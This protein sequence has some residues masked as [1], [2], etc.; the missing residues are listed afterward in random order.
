MEWLEIDRRRLGTGMLVFGVSGVLIATVVAIALVLGG[1]AVRDLDDRLEA[2]QGRIAASLTRLSVT[3]ESLALTTDN[4]SAT[5][6]ASSQS[7]AEAQVVMAS[8]AETLAALSSALDI[9]ILGSRPFATASERM[10]ALAV[11]IRG[12][13]ARAQALAADLEQNA[14]DAE[15]ITGQVRELKR[16]VTELTTRV[17]S[18]DQLGELVGLLIGGIAL[19]A[20]LTAWVGLAAAACAWAG[21]RLR[22]LGA[23]GVMHAAVVADDP[24]HG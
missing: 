21:W 9:T 24:A 3:M 1:L 5:L 14:E 16:L 19:A 11:A 23:P 20:L 22:A 8:T 2:D 7:I 17:T 4:A 15:R 12:Y 6:A 10:A 18:F 13:E